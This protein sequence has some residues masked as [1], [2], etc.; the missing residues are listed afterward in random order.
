[1]KL[2]GQEASASTRRGNKVSSRSFR[3]L[4]ASTIDTDKVILLLDLFYLPFVAEQ[5]LVVNLFHL[6]V[7]FVFIK[8]GRMTE[9]ISNDYFE[10]LALSQR[11]SLPVRFFFFYRSEAWCITDV[12]Q[13]TSLDLASSWEM[14]KPLVSRISPRDLCFTYRWMFPADGNE[15]TFEIIRSF[16]DTLQA[17]QVFPDYEDFERSFQEWTR[18][19]DQDLETE[20]RIYEEQR[21]F[22][23]D[24]QLS[25]PID[26]PIV[27]R[28]FVTSLFH[29]PY[30]IDAYTFFESSSATFSIPF[31]QWTDEDGYSQ[32]KVYLSPDQNRDLNYSLLKP[33]TRAKPNTMFFYVLVNDRKMNEN[34]YISG[35]IFWDSGFIRIRY[36]ERVKDKAGVMFLRDKFEESFKVTFSEDRIED[37]EFS[38]Y[39][40]YSGANFRK[41]VFYYLILTDPLF[42][43]FFTNEEKTSWASESSKFRI[44]YRGFRL[45]NTNLDAKTQKTITMSFTIDDGI[46]KGETVFTRLNIT[47]AIGKREA[48]SFFDEFRYL[49]GYIGR[50]SDEIIGM[51][52]NY[53]PQIA[54]TQVTQRK[55]EVATKLYR[56]KIDLLRERAGEI[57]LKSR[58]RIVHCKYEPVIIDEQDRE[59]WEELRVTGRDGRAEKRHILEFPPRPTPEQLPYVR[60][61]DN[62][63]LYVCPSDE[64]PYPRLT[65]ILAEAD[66]KYPLIP[67]CAKTRSAH[68]YNLYDIRANGF[69]KSE[70]VKE[71]ITITMKERK[72]G[73]TGLLPKEVDEFLSHFILDT[74]LVRNGADPGPSSFL[75]ALL[76]SDDLEGVAD[77]APSFFGEYNHDVDAETRKN[78]HNEIR[79]HASQYPWLCKQEMFDNTL[80]EIGNSLADPNSP[81]NSALHFHV[82]EEIFNVNIFVFVEDNKNYYFEIPRSAN[83]NIRL[84]RE[85]RPCVLLI[86]SY[87]LGKDAYYDYIYTLTSDDNSDLIG[88]YRATQQ[89]YVWDKDILSRT[90]VRISPYDAPGKNLNLNWEELLAPETSTRSIVSQ[91]IDGYGKARI[92]N[93]QLDDDEI[94]SVFTLPTQPLD[95][96]VEEEIYEISQDTAERY[97]GA[98][99]KVSKSGFYYR[100][101]DFETGIFVPTITENESPT[102]DL[103]M[104][105]QMASPGGELYTEYRQ[106]KRT[107]NLL[108]DC[109]EWCWRNDAQTR[110]AADWFDDYVEIGDILEQNIRIMDNELKVAFPRLAEFS[111]EAAIE[112]L[113]GWWYDGIFDGTRS[114]IILFNELHKRLQQYFIDLD[115]KTRSYYPV[116]PMRYVQSEIRS[117]FLISG[118]NIVISDITAYQNY[119][120]GIRHRNSIE[121]RKKIN[122]D[123]DFPQLLDFRD[124]IYIVQPSSRGRLEE[125]LMI[126]DEWKKKAFNIGATDQELP[127]EGVNYG[128][129]V[130]DDSGI[131]AMEDFTSGRP[132]YLEVLRIG[133]TK[134]LAMLRML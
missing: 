27:E 58:S 88:V 46:V 126:A 102:T 31:L 39:A 119:V 116:P 44:D 131:I 24:L 34:S 125:V 19:I 127:R 13:E 5:L 96:P 36:P 132:D 134:H 128:V 54:D 121:I 35:E 111:T 66:H 15:E 12:I 80:E 8:N 60:D 103:D 28:T 18:G 56:R 108:R 57:Y 112:S 69:P 123:A 93:V 76:Q 74:T 85:D 21:D 133:P 53:I 6:F 65:A 114:K 113:S 4:G 106:T 129:Y 117:S 16:L 11:K 51:F 124:R 82:F 47:K 62:T 109:I 71:N 61:G 104:P 55:G 67:K 97:F 98:P 68:E 107:S 7:I 25:V 29:L 37:I 95:V 49:L 2:N 77:I 110:S 101:F 40:D 48:A 130:Q 23:R 70:A 1:V 14:I 9:M 92:L 72:L 91:F 63:Q 78:I 120:Q 59:D 90:M 79:K 105:F 87:P 122:L 42:R 89:N 45:E 33:A 100:I 20:R 118:D 75:S 73:E 94:V 30:D 99:S 86:K 115:R 81:L 38:G 52:N 83:M 84:L 3:R 22:I 32:V 26:F 17:A 64:Y 41:E 50:R 43:H 10:L